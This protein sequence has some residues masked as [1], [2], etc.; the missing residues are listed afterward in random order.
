MINK[1]LKN[2]RAKLKSANTSNNQSIDNEYNS[3]IDKTKLNKLN[4]NNLKSIEKSLDGE[5][6]FNITP[7]EDEIKRDLNRIDRQKNTNKNKQKNN[8][9]FGNN[10]PVDYKE[11][12]CIF[13]YIYQIKFN[14]ICF[15]IK[16]GI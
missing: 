2:I 5:I 14:F 13:I 12:E 4:S 10:I 7:D 1:N 11:T 6:S 15:I 8:I 3:D 9:N 16:L